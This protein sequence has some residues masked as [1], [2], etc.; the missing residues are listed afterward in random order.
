M[1]ATP[2][3]PAVV[4]GTFVG[5]LGGQVIAAT[6]GVLP[7]VAPYALALTVIGGIWA[8]FMGSKKSKV[9]V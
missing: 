1:A 6:T 9:R 4:G 5:D 7:D 2:P 3:D 8:R